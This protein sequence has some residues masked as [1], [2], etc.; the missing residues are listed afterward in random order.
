MVKNLTA[1]CRSK[2]ELLVS[3]L[4]VS[5]VKI[6]KTTIVA[7]AVDEIS[8]ASFGANCG[9]MFIKRI[10]QVGSVTFERCKFVYSLP[11]AS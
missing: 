2:T 11:G 6:F 7:V 10:C 1:I 5:D 8:F 4:L 3:D 9:K